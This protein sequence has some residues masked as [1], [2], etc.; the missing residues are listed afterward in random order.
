MIRIPQLWIGYCHGNFLFTGLSGC[1]R[2]KNSIC[3]C[4]LISLCIIQCHLCRHICRIRNRIVDRIQGQFH[5]CRRVI[6]VQII[7]QIIILHMHRRR[8]CQ[9]NI[10]ENT[11][12][13]DHVLIL[14][15]GSVAEFKHLNRKCILLSL[16]VKQIGNIEGMRIIAVLTVTDLYPIHIQI[17]GRLH[18]AQRD[19]NLTVILKHRILHG[20]LLSVKSYRILFRR[21]HRK[22]CVTLK[23]HNRIRID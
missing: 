5:I 1:D 7:V 19:I 23:R 21:C 3:L 20:K 2:T 17:I 6:F 10:S 14:K 4:N 8:T 22:F 16:C 11:A 13:V 15:P 18:A 9:I 12:I